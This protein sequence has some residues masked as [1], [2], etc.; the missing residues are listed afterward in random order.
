MHT[1][2][3]V[4]FAVVATVAVA[5]L[6]SCLAPEQRYAVLLDDPAGYRVEVAPGMPGALRLEAPLV[7][8]TGSG[9]EV[10]VSIENRALTERRIEVRTEWFDGDGFLQD[11]VASAW[12]PITIGGRGRAHLRRVAPD[13][14]TRRLVIHV[15]PRDEVD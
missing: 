4:F 12:E 9:V 10:Q 2:T 8:D 11:D 5:A 3:R 6:P 13:D 1:T 7:R 15:R 14:R